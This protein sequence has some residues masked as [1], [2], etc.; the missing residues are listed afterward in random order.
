MSIRSLAREYDVHRRTVR[1]AIASPLPP[2]RKRPVRAAPVREQRGAGGDEAAIADACPLTCACG[3]T[4]TSLPNS[5]GWRCRPRVSAFSISSDAD[6][7]EIVPW[8]QAALP[9]Q[10]S[11]R[12]WT[13]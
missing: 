7:A 5:A 12:H 2:D 6:L 11:S 9:I 13:R 8:L 10:L 3:P 1:Q 4:R